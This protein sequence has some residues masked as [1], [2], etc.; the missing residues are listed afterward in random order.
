MA[1]AEI[2][3]CSLVPALFVADTVKVYE[4]PFVKPVTMHEG[5][6]VLPAGTVYVHE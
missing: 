4:R 2:A 6:A 3:D 1:E 5:A